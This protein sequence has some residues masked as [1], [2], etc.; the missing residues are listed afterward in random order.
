MGGE[1][2]DGQ[3]P[4]QPCAE[5]IDQWCRN[6]RH[7]KLRDQQA[8]LSRKLRGHYAY[9]GITGNAQALGRLRY[10]VERR[11]ASG[12]VGVVGVGACRGNDSRACSTPIP[13]PLCASCTVCTVE[14]RDHYLRSRV[15]EWGTP[16]SG[17]PGELAKGRGCKSP[18]TKE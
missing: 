15:P 9:Y 18:V 13:S 11:G 12:L 7:W 17:A 1:A 16:G 2:Q 10:E 3:G 5:G 6:H 4:I 8:A 14:Q